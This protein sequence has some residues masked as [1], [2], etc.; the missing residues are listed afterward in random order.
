MES[1]SSEKFWT[2]VK[3]KFLSRKLLVWV[4]ATVLLGFKMISEDVWMYTS[5]VYIGVNT[6][7]AAIEVLKK[8]QGKLTEAVP[9]AVIEPGNKLPPA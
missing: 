2:F 6:A 4:T 5:M 7:L 1:T 3:E 8:K 9:D